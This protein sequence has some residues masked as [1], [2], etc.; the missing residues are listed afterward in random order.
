MFQE[1]SSRRLSVNFVK[2]CMDYFTLGAPMS[3]GVTLAF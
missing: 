2:T 3:K 1:N